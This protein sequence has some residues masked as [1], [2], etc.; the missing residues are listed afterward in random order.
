[1]S[2][3]PLERAQ[4]ARGASAKDAT[5]WPCIFVHR[6]VVANKL[7]LEISDV[8]VTLLK[9]SQGKTFMFANLNTETPV[10][11]TQA[12]GDAIGAILSA[13]ADIPTITPEGRDTIARLLNRFVV[14]PVDVDGV[15]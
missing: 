3:D 9:A 13:V 11:V 2:A 12:D 6:D 5:P 4:I 7:K 15:V 14:L 1:M 10:P 8:A